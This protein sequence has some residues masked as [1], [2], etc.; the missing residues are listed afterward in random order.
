LLAEDYYF[1]RDNKEKNLKL[2]E[3]YWQLAA[4]KGQREA[5]L[6]LNELIQ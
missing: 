3:K 2:A 5:M 6:R 4:K 1:G